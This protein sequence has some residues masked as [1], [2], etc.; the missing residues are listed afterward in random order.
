VS[1]PV[2]K[3][4]FDREAQPRL[5]DSDHVFGVANALQKRTLLASARCLLFPI[6]WEEP[7]G[8][9]MIEAMACAGPSLSQAV[10]ARVEPIDRPPIIV[11]KRG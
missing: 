11:S 7:F 6:Q 9:V 8:M 1:E 5:T 4:Y 3:A 2:E 10:F